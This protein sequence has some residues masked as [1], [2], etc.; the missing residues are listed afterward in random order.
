MCGLVGIGTTF[1]TKE[2]RN[3]MSLLLFLDT[4]RGEDST[5]IA[6]VRKDRSTEVLKSTV[7]G[8]EFIQY[9]EF[10]NFLDLSDR[11]WIGHNRFGTV[12]KK[13]K[14]NAHPFLVLNDD[15]ECEL[16]GAHNGTITNTWDL[17]NFK[18]FGTDSEALFNLIVEK[19]LKETVANLDGAWALTWYSP[20][21][22]RLFFLKNEKRP[23][24][25]AYQKDRKSIIW[26]SKAWMIRAATHE[27]GIE[28]ENDEV[29]KV[30]D[31]T[32]YTFKIPS[33]YKESVSLE[34]KEGG[35]SGKPPTNFLPHSAAG[36]GWWVEQE[37][38]RK[39]AEAQAALN[40][41]TK[42][43]KSGESQ[44]VTKPS[45]SDKE[46]NVVPIGIGKVSYKGFKGKLL[47][48]LEIVSQLK[49]GCSWC[50]IEDISLEERFAW[51]ADRKPVCR[52][53]IDGVE[54]KEVNFYRS[55]N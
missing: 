3:C 54:E 5:G 53:C 14:A 41:G 6:S 28:I 25:Y 7:P 50:E 34:D 49:G 17:S 55:V 1:A 31:D 38:R 30:E 9:R 47:S 45:A 24:F 29:F 36:Q 37:K 18:D 33:G 52:K 16:V 4:L 12:G 22:D 39:A 23:L 27:S 10:S 32:L 20:R 8:T 19:G 35:F 13:S 44:E 15:E 40:S 43:V 21:E 48:F 46:G 26:A 42:T 11:L 51:L 2:Q